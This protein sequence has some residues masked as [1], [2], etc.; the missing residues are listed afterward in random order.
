VQQGL[1][2]R[3]ALERLASPER[4][5]ELMEVT[6][7][8]GWLALAALIGLIAAAFLWGILG[9][10]PTLVRGDGVL[11]REGSLQT[12]DASAAGEVKELFARAGDDVEQN[13]VVARIV[14]LADNRTTFVTSSYAGRVLEVRVTPGNQVSV[15][16]AL[17]SLEQAGRSLQAVVY[18]APTDGKKVR[19]GME[20]QL[21]PGSVRK[22]EYGLLL[23]RVSWVGGFPATQAGMRQA[24]GS[25]ELARTLS[26]NGPPI[27][28]RVELTRNAR[29][30]SGYQWTSTL[31]TLGALVDAVLP[32]PV[33]NLLPAWGN[34]QGPPIVLASGTTCTAD[35]VTEQQA[36]IYF[37]L[38]KL[39][40]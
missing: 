25:D 40:R 2:R 26:A 23:G 19:P 35:V 38:A 32:D 33:A 27:E 37:V 24:L 17:L 16:T 11:I 6:T 1:F 15:G 22:E 3:P 10:V 34:A 9:S 31:S 21:A 12:V 28:V 39:S 8:Q 14:D 30:A 29:T 36:P 20:V 13:Q 5:D 4:L 7:A 18:V